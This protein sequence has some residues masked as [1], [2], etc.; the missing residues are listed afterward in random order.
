MQAN[1]NVKGD[2]GGVG[3]IDSPNALQRWMVAGPEMLRMVA[4]FEDDSIPR[5]SKHHEQT[6]K[7]VQTTFVKEVKA[8]VEVFEEIGKI[9]LLTLDT[10]LSMDS[11][12]HKVVENAYT[13]GQ[14]QYEIFVKE[15]FVYRCLPQV[16]RSK[17]PR[18]QQ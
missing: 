14:E 12:V 8:L 17:C 16:H 5:S 9:D 10:K 6:T 1:A 2:G 18:L 15:R 3:L 7:A 11:E 13:V 4:E